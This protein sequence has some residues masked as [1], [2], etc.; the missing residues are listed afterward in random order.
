MEHRWG[1]RVPVDIPVSL[2][3]ACGT[4]VPARLVDLSVSGAR[5]QTDEPLALLS[6]VTV[7]L[8]R[9]LSE[10]WARTVCAHIV[11]LAFNEAGVEWSEFSPPEIC[12]E[13]L[14]AAERPS[15]SAELQPEST[16]EVEFLPSKHHRYGSL[17]RSI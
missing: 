1:Q 3:L 15:V 5:V 11:R 9:Y 7:L 6:P 17:Q 13:L 16:Q 14:E 8:D 4:L 12:A 10:P 2:R